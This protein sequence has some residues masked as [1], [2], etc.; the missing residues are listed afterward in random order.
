MHPSSHGPSGT[1]TGPGKSRGPGSG[2]RDLPPARD[3]PRPGPRREQR[4]S[5]AWSAGPRPARGPRGGRDEQR[6]QGTGATGLRPRPE[7]SRVDPTSGPV[8]GQGPGPGRSNLAE[9][10]RS[11]AIRRNARQKKASDGH[12]PQGGAGGWGWVRRGRTAHEGMLII[13][14][15]G[16]ALP[17][18]VV[19]EIFWLTAIMIRIDRHEE[20][21][22]SVAPCD[23]KMQCPPSAAIRPL[24]RGSCCL[25]SS[26]RLRKLRIQCP[27]R[28][29]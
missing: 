8:H 12:P 14:P 6:R 1:G 4:R 10:S 18:I 17:W 28:L 27:A 5:R 29:K 20:M 23:S 11:G 15:P 21:S 13:A 19:H 26:E 9:P 16:C 3:R 25:L 2:P 7:R 22:T 24:W